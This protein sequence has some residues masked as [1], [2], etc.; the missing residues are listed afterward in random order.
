LH[1]HAYTVRTFVE[2]QYFA[3]RSL[4]HMLQLHPELVDAYGARHVEV[5][6]RQ[7]RL[8][9]EGGRRTEAEDA[10][11]AI[12][13]K[14]FTLDEQNRL[15]SE[16]WHGDFLSALFE[17]ACH[18]GYVSSRAAEELNVAAARRA[19]LSRFRSRVKHVER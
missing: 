7:P 14:A 15:G 10:I 8:N 18:D 1:H 16:G 5:A 17:L 4:R 6:L 19:I 13:V 11:E 3:G 2:R 12:K 9:Q